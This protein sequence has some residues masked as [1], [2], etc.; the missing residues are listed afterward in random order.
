MLTNF[1]LIHIV[2]VIF[3]CRYQTRTDSYLLKL[4]KNLKKEGKLK[5]VFIAR[6]SLT[7]VICNDDTLKYIRQKRDLEEDNLKDGIIKGGARGH[8]GGGGG[9]GGGHSGH[10][11]GRGGKGRGGKGAD[12]GRGGGGDRGR[13]GKNVQFRRGGVRGRGGSKG[14][15]GKDGGDDLGGGTALYLRRVLWSSGISD[16]TGAMREENHCNIPQ[17]MREESHPSTSKFDAKKV[18]EVLAKYGWKNGM[19]LGIANQG[20]TQGL[21]VEKTSN[22]PL[23]AKIVPL[24]IP[25]ITG[26]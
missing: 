6:S 15:G 1:T 10:G 26:I 17:M 13:G 21:M 2:S 12:R 20:T 7:A 8:G 14:G 9:G 22:D 5:H 11:E 16:K 18:P 23:I 24:P 19:G 25:V 3:Y 4:A